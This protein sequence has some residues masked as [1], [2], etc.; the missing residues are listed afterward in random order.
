M[1]AVILVL[2]AIMMYAFLIKPGIDGYVVNKQLDAKDIVL[3]AMLAQ[4]EQQGYTQISDA[5]GNTI[6]LIPYVPEQP[7]E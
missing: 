1:I 6:V 2:V 4:I 3:S 5:E 7:Q